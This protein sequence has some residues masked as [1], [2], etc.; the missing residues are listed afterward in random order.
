[1]EKQN[2]YSVELCRYP[3]RVYVSASS[4][5]DAIKKAKDKAGFSI[6]SV[7]SVEVTE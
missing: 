4:E 1:M 5:A 2:K 6:W 7:E 3:V